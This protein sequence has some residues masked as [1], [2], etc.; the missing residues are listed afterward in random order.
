MVIRAKFAKTMEIVAEIVRKS[1]STSSSSTSVPTVRKSGRIT[2]GIPPRRYGTF[3]NVAPKR[4]RKRK[5]VVVKALENAIECSSTKRDNILTTRSDNMDLIEVYPDGLPEGGV[6]GVNVKNNSVCDVD[7]IIMEGENA[8]LRDEVAELRRQMQS[9]RVEKVALAASGQ[10][11]NPVSSTPVCAKLDE[12]NFDEL[13]KS[14]AANFITAHDNRSE[15]SSNNYSYS[16]RPRNSEHIMNEIKAMEREYEQERKRE[17]QQQHLERGSSHQRTSA[18]GHQQ[19]ECLSGQQRQWRLEQQQESLVEQQRQWRLEQQ[20]ECLAEQQRQWRLEQ[21]RKRLEEQQ[22]QWRM[23]QQQKRLAEQQ[24]QWRLE[25]QRMAKQQQQ[26]LS[27]EQQKQ[28]W[29]TEQRE[30]N[31]VEPKQPWL[32]EQHQQK[33]PTQDNFAEQQQQYKTQQTPQWT[34][35]HR[36]FES[37]PPTGARAQHDRVHDGRVDDNLHQLL[38]RQGSKDLPRFDGNPDDWLL[39]SSQYFRTT[40]ACRFSHD[41]NLSRLHRSLHGPAREAVRTML[42]FPQCVDEIMNTL[43][44]RFG[45]DEHIIKNLITKAR[46][47]AAPRDDEPHSIIEFSTAVNNMVVTLEHLGRPD[48]LRNPQLLDDLESKLPPMLSMLWSNAVLGLDQHTLV[49][50]NKWIRQQSSVLSKRVLPKEFSEKKERKT[51]HRVYAVAE[52][53]SPVKD[54]APNTRASSACVCCK[55]L[56][57]S[58]NK[59]DSFMKKSVDDRWTLVKK[60]FVCFSCLQPGHTSMRCRKNIKCSVDKCGARHHVLLHNAA[61]VPATKSGEPAIE[62]EACMQTST[63]NKRVLLKI[64]PVTLRV[65]DKTVETSALLDSGSTATLVRHDIARK[66]HASGPTQTLCVQWADGSS[67]CDE[68]SQVINIEVRGQHDGA[69]E[70][71]LKSVKTIQRLPLLKQSIRSTQ[72]FNDWPYLRGL[73]IIDY[74]D[75]QPGILIGEDHAFLQSAKRVVRGQ[76]HTPIAT[77]TAL[78]WTVSGN[79]AVQ[80]SESVSPSVVVCTINDDVPEMSELHRLVKESFMLDDFGVKPTQAKGRSR[81]DERALAI[82]EQTV[83]RMQSS[84]RWEIGLLWRD[85]NVALPDSEGMAMSRLRCLERRLDA[86]VSLRDMYTTKIN[87]YISN[88][89]FVRASADD[90]NERRKWFVPHFA[91]FNVNKPNKI[92]VVFDAAAKASGRSL[93]DY[94]LQGPDMLKALTGVLFRFRQRRIGFVGDIKEMYHRV[95]IRAADQTCQL[96]LWR[97]DDRQRQPDVFKMTAMTFGASCSPSAAMYVKDKNAMEFVQQYPQAV[98]VIIDNHYVDDCLASADTEEDAVQLIRDVMHVHQNGGFEIRNWACS[99]TEVMKSIPEEKRMAASKQIVAADDMERVLG[100]WWEPIN[101]IFT[102]R[103]KHHDHLAA[104]VTPTKR[105]I[106]RILMTVYDPLGMLAHVLI[107]GRIIMQNIWKSAI[108]WDDELTSAQVVLWRTFIGDLADIHRVQVPR[109]YSTMFSTANNVQLHIFCDASEQAYCAVAYFRIES[110]SA[111]DTAFVVAKARVA[112][113]KTCTIPRLELQAALIGSRLAT[114]IVAEHDIKPHRVI[115]WSDSRTVLCWVRAENRRFRQYAA[116]R[117]GEILEHTNAA[118]WRWVPTKENVADDATRMS[119][120]ICYEPT[121]RW[122]TGPMFLKQHESEW[123]HEKIVHA[124]DEHLEVIDSVCMQTNQSVSSCMDRYSTIERAVRV[125]GWTLR[126]INRFWTKTRDPA[127]DLTAMELKRAEAECIFE[128]QRESFP[129]ELRDVERGEPMTKSSRLYKLCPCSGRDGL[130]R[131][132]SR[133]ENLDA[134]NDYVNPVILDGK[135]RFCVMLLRKYHN[136]YNHQNDGTVLNE[137]RQKYWMIGARQALKRLKQTCIECRIRKA[138]PEIQLMG[139]L[140]RVRLEYGVPPFTYCGVDYFGPMEIVVGRR[141]E[142]RYGVLF[143]CM[144]CRAVHLEVAAS[145]STDVFLMAWR[146]FVSRR[147]VPKEMIS[148]NG[149]NFRGADSELARAKLELIDDDVKTAVAIRGVVWK[150]I[151]PGSPHFGGCWERLVRSVKNSLNV[152]LRNR[153]P[154][155]DELLHTLIVEA[156]NV[157]NSRPLTELPMDHCD[158]DVITPNHLLIG[159]SSADAPVGKFDDNDLILRK[160][161]RASQRLADVFW[162][163]WV[164]SYLPS[165]TLRPKWQ[166]MGR[167]LSIGDVVLIADANEPRNSWPRGVIDRVYPGG[168]GSVRVVDVRTASG[169]MKRPA[170]KICL[171]LR[172][173]LS[174]PV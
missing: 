9:L 44:E 140:P 14:S 67:S 19:Q 39:F 172:P 149:T 87:E 31:Y 116:Q 90:L 59:C 91:V 162:T 122:Y 74:V 111:V 60:V 82:M 28:R 134:E 8:K 130:L 23:E 103:F 34:Q 155:T 7:R 24:Q 64:I 101:D 133:L 43:Y 6:C 147:G 174:M 48:H 3:L 45:R 52:Q 109:C 156:E 154:P 104:N 25:Q 79:S 161:W 112:P 15:S 107:R 143:T 119:S 136:R 137:I 46:K 148:D 10:H 171:L 166:K 69:R 40:N 99:S 58:L 117:V 49:D 102:Y 81:E 124:S 150:F 145:L 151:P 93:N 139:Q 146:R 20:Q 144:T 22:Q 57:V 37:L 92:R 164:R 26:Q 53:Q 62:R 129:Q 138:T 80:S 65:G 152:T 106:L 100:V 32:E 160:Q 96:I 56:C 13:C 38:S 115:L 4:D 108:G 132:G 127:G 1:Q 131:V 83:V 5:S 21:H 167:K 2:R 165:L 163:I 27:S 123:P 158:D 68:N 41:E 50:L 110:E 54:D 84:Q 168:D 66:L 94:L 159:R 11:R 85:A 12:N 63:F 55:K 120:T 153:R 51:T 76:P 113:V 78:G 18:A 77:K 126:F 30:Q 71:N 95:G 105:Q 16:T 141:R 142:K 35:Q 97:G 121:D 29:L 98:K 170:H 157:V 70:F 73:P 118:D 89:Y 125:K 169:V 72:L 114:T 173:E 61:R 47:I 86:N 36:M 75:M 128:V 88:G 42:I 135:H 17:Q 33:Y